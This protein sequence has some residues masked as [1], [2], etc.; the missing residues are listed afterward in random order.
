VSDILG[1]EAPQLQ[2]GDSSKPVAEPP[3]QVIARPIDPPKPNGTRAID[4]PPQAK[5]FFF[6]SDVFFLIAFYILF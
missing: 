3:K 4:P 1:D 5:V 6:I 2:V